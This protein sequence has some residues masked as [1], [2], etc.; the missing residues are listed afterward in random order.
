MKPTHI[1]IIYRILS[2]LVI[3]APLAFLN[4]FKAEIIYSLLYVPGFILGLALIFKYVDFHLV[5]VLL[6]MQ[7]HKHSTK[8]I[9]KVVKTSGLT[10]K[11]QNRAA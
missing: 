5:R 9:I 6:T 3:L 1:I 10:A 8:N 7:V 11:E 2:I 4:V